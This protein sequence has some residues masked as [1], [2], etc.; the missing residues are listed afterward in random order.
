M[1]RFLA[2]SV[3]V[4][5][6][7]FPTSSALAQTAV[8]FV[9]NWFAEP[10]H[11]G[12]YAAKS[13]GLYEAEG[14]DLTL[15]PGGPNVTGMSLLAAGRVQFAMT[16]AAS[17]LFARDEGIPVV[18]IF[19]TFQTMPQG[20]M[21]HP[22][23]DISDFPDLEGHTVTIAPGSAYWQFIEAKYG[24]VGKVQVANYNGQIAEWLL[25]DTRVT[26]I[27]VTSEP[28]SANQEGID[29]KYLKI[30]DSG[31]NPYANII[32]T[33]EA[34]AA[35][36]PDIVRAFV[37]ASQEGW[38]A[39][40]ADPVSYTDV[41]AAENDSMTEDFVTWSSAQQVPYITDANTEKDGIGTMNLERWTTLYQ[42]LT[43]L[44]LLK[45][46]QDVSEAFT[47]EFLP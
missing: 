12:F 1:K 17:V 26:Q 14:L 30:A 19:G 45:N 18:A 27:Y 2:L 4:L 42:Q 8:S 46:E 22:N 15:M 32:V 9:T 11:G 20:L 21:Y 29:A 31:F 16:D 35:E 44:G 10:E 13:D 3:F 28:Y 6:V 5:A 38:A 40:M 39:Y 34:Y 7:L 33:T 37:K 36:N 23:Q 43:D 41:L 25:D 47:T 24:L